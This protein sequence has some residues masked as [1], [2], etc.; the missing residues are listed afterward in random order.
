MKP[1]EIRTLLADRERLAARCAKAEGALQL[2]NDL[3]REHDRLAA[4]V[5]SLRRERDHCVRHHL[6]CEECEGDC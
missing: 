1:S 6:P 3:V 2:H 5:S 4:E